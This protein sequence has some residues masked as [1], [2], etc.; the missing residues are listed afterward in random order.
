MEKLIFDLNKVYGEFK[1]L[2]ATNGGPYY[3][4][5]ASDQLRSNFTAYKAARIPYS[6]NHDSNMLSIYGGP[7]SHDITAI[8]PRFEKDENDP[9]SYDFACTD[10]SIL[11]TLEAGTKTFFR[12]GESIEHQIKKHATLPPSDFAKWARIAEHVIRHYTEGWADGFTHDMPYWEIWNEPDMNKDDDTNKMTWGGTKAQFFDFYEIAAKHLKPLFPHLKIGG[13]ALGFD[14][15]WAE[16]F[17]SEIQKRAVPI[18]FFSWH[19]Y[20][21]TPE[22]LMKHSLKVRALLDKYGYENAESIFN[23]WNYVRGWTEDFVYSIESIHGVK[24][25]AFMMATISEAQKHPIDMMMYYDTRLSVFNGAFDYYTLRPL[26]GYYPLKWFGELYG[27]GSEVRAINKIDNVYSVCGVDS[28][29][30]VM[31]IVTHYSEDDSTPDI[32]LS[33]D[34]GRHGEYDVYLLDNEHDGKL[35]ASTGDLTFDLSVHS[36]VMIKER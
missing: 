30:K 13:P 20:E 1:P 12:L 27:Y 29:G 32:S 4:R 14:L 8:F 25:A 36:V 19:M 7:Y 35:V 15:E 10:E 5:H 23:E 3:K 2:N 6:R 21:R 24:G 28:S 22:H 31:A 11:S 18:D 17:L 33:V 9:K 16:D 34:F 26:K